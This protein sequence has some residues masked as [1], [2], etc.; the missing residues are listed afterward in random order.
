MAEIIEPARSEWVIKVE[1]K[2]RSRPTGQENADLITGAIEIEVTKCSILSRAKTPPFE[3]TD[4]ST[5]SEDIRYKYRYLDLRR[6]V[7]RKKIE[8][9]ATVNA[10]AREWFRE[11]GFLEIQTPLFTVSSP[12]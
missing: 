1:G 12:E 7:Q 11:K 5:S 2:V 6:D 3:I 9:R 8:F 10:Y 4:Y